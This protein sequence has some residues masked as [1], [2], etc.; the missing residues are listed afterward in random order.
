[1]KNF[2]RTL[3]GRTV[4]TFTPKSRV[5][6]ASTTTSRLFWPLNS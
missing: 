6:S 2:E 5:L 4:T 1:M 3:F